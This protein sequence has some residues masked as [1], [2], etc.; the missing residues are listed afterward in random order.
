[1]HAGFHSSSMGALL[2]GAAS[3]IAVIV[4]IK[5]L[6]SLMLPESV[7]QKEIVDEGV[8]SDVEVLGALNDRQQRPY[9]LFTIFRNFLLL[10]YIFSRCSNYHT[11]NFPQVF[12]ERDFSIGTTCKQSAPQY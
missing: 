12:L 10:G 7:S 4:V 2:I 9:I 1:M 6:R 11:G 8:L 5:R 3:T